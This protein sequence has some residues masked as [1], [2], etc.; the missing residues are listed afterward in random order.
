[1]GTAKKA[2]NQTL[3]F[4]ILLVF[5]LGQLTRLEFYW[6]D[7]L[8]V[9]HLLDL[10][11]GLTVLLN[12]KTL[13]RS[14]HF[15]SFFWL[16][17]YLAISFAVSYFVFG[18]SNYLRGFFYLVRL[19]SQL[20]FF[21]I[22]KESALVGRF[23]ERFWVM[24]LLVAAFLGWY[25]FLTIPDLRF[26]ADFGWDDH[27][28]RLAGAFLDPGFAGL[29]M[30]LSAVYFLAKKKWFLSVFFAVTTLFTYSRASMVALLAGL[31]FVLLR[32]RQ[33]KRL[34]VIVG[35]LF[36]LVGLL[37]NRGG[38]GNNLKRTFSVVSRLINYSEAARIFSQSPLLGIGYNNYCEGKAVFLEATDTASHS[39]SGA[40]SSLL[41]LL[42][43]TG[44]VGV[45]LMGKS[46]QAF[47]VDSPSIWPLLVV[48]VVHSFFQNSFFYPWVWVMLAFT[49]AKRKP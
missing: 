31:I 21:L 28:Y 38:E 6:N 18:F 2:I 20:S 10:L 15:K 8:V 47:W 34:L 14:R 16:G 25:Q 42:A 27:Y 23:L 3:V 43:T 29:V 41:F 40:D 46:L 9:F 19:L 48:L 17:V 37:P 32:G 45:L 1:M 24:A 22:L 4:L 35:V 44:V 36:L 12:L 26:L 7:W 49:T 13:M 39:C 11:V 5:P 33:L 30:A